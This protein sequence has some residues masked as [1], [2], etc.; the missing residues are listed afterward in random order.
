M[1]MSIIGVIIFIFEKCLTMMFVHDAEAVIF[2]TNYLR[3]MNF[4]FRFLGIN[5]DLNVIVRESG[6]RYLVLFFNVI[7]FFS[8]RYTLASCFVNIYGDK[9]ISIGLGTSLIISS[10]IAAA[11]YRYGGWRSKDLFSRERK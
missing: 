7:Y 5:F 6:S 9:G 11:Y 10:L 2:A 1:I 4:C 8:L 3:I